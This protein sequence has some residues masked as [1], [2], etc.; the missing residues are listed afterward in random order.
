LFDEDIV[1]ACSRLHDDTG[2]SRLLALEARMK[3]GQGE[4]IVS[5]PQLNA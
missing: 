5:R 2:L 3:S 1:N 4:A